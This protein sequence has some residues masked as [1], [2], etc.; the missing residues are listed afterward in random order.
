MSTHSEPTIAQRL[1]EFVTDL[2]Y[3]DLPPDVVKATKALIV[4]QLACELIGSTM[5]WLAPARQLVEETRGV[6]EESTIVGSGGT[7][8]L[9]ADAAFCN[10]SYGQACELDDSPYGSAGHIGTATVPVAMAMGERDRIDGTQFLV[11]IVAGYE[12]MYRLMRSVAP[13]HDTRGFHSQSI[14]GPFA[15]AAIAGKIIG[16]NAGEMT[17]ALAIAGSHSC[18]PLEYDQSGGEVK[19]I[20]AGLGARGGIDSA[21][22]AKFGLTGPSTIIEGKRGFCRIFATEC[23]PS[24]ITPG[25]GETFNV[26]NSGFKMYPTIGGVQT[27]IAAAE[28]IVRKQ[29]ISPADIARVRVG[30]A[31]KVLLHG[32]GIRVP[33][34]VIGAQFSLAFSLALTFSGM[35]NHLEHYMN[36]GLWRD[37][38]LVDLMMKVE[39]Y[40]H[41]D[42]TG[43]N[44]RLANVEVE[45]KDGR[46]F[47]ATELHQKGSPKNPATPEEFEAKAR[48]LA[49]TV[50][51]PQNFDAILEMICGL[52]K[53]ED[54]SVLARL[55]GNGRGAMH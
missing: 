44:E 30:L 12:V 41:P 8:R 10:A 40:A 29:E 27:S 19:R 5:P 50:L 36:A 16:L 18:G 51:T 26:T 24:A 32:A 42:A 11:S 35:G 4:D 49:T 38:H 9:A 25:L 22:L 34:D 6:R 45:L 54:V 52:E 43:I 31:E 48:R 21:F 28:S 15:S 14:A 39:T 33:D 55:L 37:P 47:E 17:H 2:R 1:A 3:D 7:R 46:K 53:L 13:H 20:H 23:D